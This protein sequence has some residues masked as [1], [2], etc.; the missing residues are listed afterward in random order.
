M[1]SCYDGSNTIVLKIA[2][3]NFGV[4][5]TIELLTFE[6]VFDLLFRLLWSLWF[7]LVF[8]YSQRVDAC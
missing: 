1:E 2:G 8:F 5:F 4:C 3:G 7:R 6:G